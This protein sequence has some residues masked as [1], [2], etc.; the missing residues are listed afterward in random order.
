MPYSEEWGCH[1][2][3]GSSPDA[4]SQPRTFYDSDELDELDLDSQPGESLSV[5]RRA[6][7][8]RAAEQALEKTSRYRYNSPVR[9]SD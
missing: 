8:R 3:R 7:K 6:M 2:H 5:A 4:W 9:D 1:V